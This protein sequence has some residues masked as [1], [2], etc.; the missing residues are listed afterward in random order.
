[1]PIRELAISDRPGA[2]LETLERLAPPPVDVAFLSRIDRNSIPRLSEKLALQ[3]IVCERNTGDATGVERDRSP[4]P[5]FRLAVDGATTLSTRYDKLE[6]RT[7]R[8]AQLTLTS[9]SR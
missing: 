4:I 6:L 2:D 1:M 9:R 5:V 7:F 8:G 3:A